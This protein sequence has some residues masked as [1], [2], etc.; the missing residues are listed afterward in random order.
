MAEFSLALASEDL[1]DETSM[2]RRG[3]GGLEEMKGEG[4]KTKSAL[5]KIHR[6]LKI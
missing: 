6:E 2:D 5:E 3:G 4:N 1:A